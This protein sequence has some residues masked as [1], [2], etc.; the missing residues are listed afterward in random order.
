M[1]LRIGS[2]TLSARVL[3]N[4]DASSSRLA[5]NYAALSSGARINRASDDAA[6][7]A[8]ADSLRA[9]ARVYTQGI[10]NGN[11]GLSLLNIAQGSLSELSSVATRLKELAQQSANG[12][13]SRIQRLALDNEASALVRETNRILGSTT[14][15][16]LNLL[17]R[18]ETSFR[19]QTDYGLN[20]GISFELTRALDRNQGVGLGES[21]QVG[22]V[23]VQ[24]FKPHA[25]DIDGDGNI[26]LVYADSQ[27][28]GVTVRF[29]NGDGTF[30]AESNFATAATF[31]GEI[32][33]GDLDG[34]GDLDLFQNEG[35]TTFTLINSGGRSFSAGA[36]VASGIVGAVETYAMADINGDGRQDLI[37]G[38]SA[39]VSVRLGQSGGGLSA[40]ATAYTVTGSV[41]DIAVGDVDGD[42]RLD[43]IAGTNGIGGGVF[44][45]LSSADGALSV[46]KISDSTSRTVAL[47]D[48]NRDGLLDVALGSAGSVSI[49]QQSAEG[50]FSVSKSTTLA[51]AGATFVSFADMNSD[52]ELDL[53]A[54]S[55]GFIETFIGDGTASFTPF[56]S[57]TTE[58]GGAGFAVADF[59]SDGASD[60]L[61][62]DG[63][64]QV[65][66][67]NTEVVTSVKKFDLT[68][69]E[70]ALQA[71]DQIGELLDSFAM[72]Q[73]DIGSTQSRIQVAVDT[74]VSG[75]LNISAAEGRIRD[76]DIS[77]ETAALAREKILQSVSASLLAQANQAPA[78]ALDLLRAG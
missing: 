37:S 26:D 14:F 3:R 27:D 52:G 78:L 13:Y 54:Q 35:G 67:N 77:A 7:L 65:K 49:L 72:A 61:L 31:G 23:D 19:I 32:G 73:G 56:S 1:S 39:M 43:L 38:G 64:Y 8:I 59:N 15:N 16:G 34:D 9:R 46:S 41:R 40:T 6:G 11:D 69:R 30:T 33:V 76:A 60:V 44:R 12:A 58:G 70:S 63:A 68:T 55:S 22:T 17:N 29:G 5:R 53:V 42:G 66:F 45:M 25:V 50:D 51:G 4:L 21:V 75:T 24:D 28:P 20:G 2:N 47:G 57:S 62:A 71:L 74:L 10:R 48:V 18:S 36:S